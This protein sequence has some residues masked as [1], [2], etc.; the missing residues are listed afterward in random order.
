MKSTW[1]VVLKTEAE[2]TASAGREAYLMDVER[3]YNDE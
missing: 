1:I 2:L 3:I